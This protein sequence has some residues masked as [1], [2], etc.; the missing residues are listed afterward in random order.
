MTDVTRQDRWSCEATRCDWVP[1]ATGPA[2]GTCFRGYNRRGFR[3]WTRSNKI[4]AL[5]PG[6]TFVWETLPSRLYPDSTEWRVELRPDGRGTMVTES[7]RITKLLRI[8]EAFLYWFNPTHRER[9]EDLQQDL[10]G[11]KSFIESGHASSP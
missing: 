1:P 8:L 6:R 5:E 9:Q 10:L 2:V 7:F 3:R 11:L 4:V